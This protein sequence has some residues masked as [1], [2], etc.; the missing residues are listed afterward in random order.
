MDL[1]PVQHRLNELGF[2]PLLEDGIPGNRTNLAIKKFQFSKGLTADGI[3]G[4]KTIQA[5]GID[6]PTTPIVHP[7]GRMLSTAEIMAE[8]GQP[9]PQNLVTIDLPYPMRIE[10]APG[11]ICRK[12]QCHKKVADRLHQVFVDI[13]AAYGLE[14]IK[15]LGIDLYAGCYNLRKM[16]GGS[17]WSRHSWGIAI[18]LYSE[19]NLLHQHHD[20][21]L[22][23]TPPYQKMI[24]CFYKNGFVGLGPEEDRDWMHWQSGS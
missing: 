4:P 9:G 23:A 17:E 19:K 6:V 13:L 21:A 18:D 3:I 11:T 5:L 12:I 10:W 15:E 7:K 22:F 16:R 8:Y 20:T 2:G 1:K 14:K 24:E